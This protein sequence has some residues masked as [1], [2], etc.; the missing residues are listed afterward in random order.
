MLIATIFTGFFGFKLIILEFI[1]L[2]LS[3]IFTHMFAFKKKYFLI[4]ENT[5]DIDL[6]K[7]KKRGKFVIIYRN[8]R[9]TEKINSLK[10]N[11]EK[12]VV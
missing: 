9:I 3:T 8:A 6:K 2:K 1:L 7:I 4:I 5:K 10:K 12:I 11:L